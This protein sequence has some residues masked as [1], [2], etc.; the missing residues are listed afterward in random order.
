M[1]GKYKGVQAQILELNKYALFTPCAAHSLNLV[2]ASAAECCPAVTTFFGT[3]QKL[4]TFMSASPQRWEIL[5]ECLPCS[6]HGQSHTRWSER[7]DAVRPVAAHLPSILRAIEGVSKLNLSPEAKVTVDCLYDYFNSFPA[8]IMSAIWIK[9]LL[10]IDRRSKVLQARKATIDVEVKNLHSLL[11]DLKLLRDGW[12]AILTEA[13]LVAESMNIS[14]SLPEK[15]T[16]KRRRFFDESNDSEVIPQPSTSS[17]ETPEEIEFRQTVFYSLIDNVISGITE[18]F[19]AARDINNLFSFLW[20]YQHIDATE[21]K[22]SAENFV[23][24][25]SSDVSEELVEECLLLK[26][27]HCANFTEPSYSPLDLL[28][29]IHEL[30]LENLLPNICI[31]LR[32]FC[33]LSVSVAEAE[34]SFSKLNIVKNYLR[35]TMTQDRLQNLAL[36]SIENQLAKTVNFKDIIKHFAS[37]K[38][39]RISFD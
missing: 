37:I 10:A 4:Y 30:K 32:I 39:R 21:L 5:L 31:S 15:R 12:G 26:S 16:R 34:R 14:P 27:I 13:K 24:F 17:G 35:S 7:V 11:Q 6:L 38:A 28:N 25:Y 19:T 1:S 2:G 20:N 9:V 8:V 3:V 23:S 33:T 29:K 36:L 22:S 18:R